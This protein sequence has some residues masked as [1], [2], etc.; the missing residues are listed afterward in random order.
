MEGDVVWP[1]CLGGIGGSSAGPGNQSLGN[2]RK[3][4]RKRRASMP[5]LW[6]ADGLPGV[7]SGRL[8]C[9][10]RGTQVADR[11]PTGSFWTSTVSWAS[12]FR[13]AHIGQGVRPKREYG[14]IARN[15]DADWS[16]ALSIWRRTASG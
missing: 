6:A 9:A 8:S 15:I 3:V 1:S 5:V 14:G 11:H 13:L 4:R 10:V 16:P 12:G 7:P 2:D